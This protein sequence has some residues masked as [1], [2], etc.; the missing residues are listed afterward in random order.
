MLARLHRLIGELI[1][2]SI[3]RNAFEPWEIEILL[4]VETC[5]L[6]ARINEDGRAAQAR[7]FLIRDDAIVDQRLLN[8]KRRRAPRWPYFLRSFMRL[9]RVR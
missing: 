3:S 5:A 1:R 2:G 8:W 6:D 4:D 9:S 7:P